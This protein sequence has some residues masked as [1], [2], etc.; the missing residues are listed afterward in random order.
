MSFN[1]SLFEAGSRTPSMGLALGALLRLL[2][3]T[4]TDSICFERHAALHRHA[5]RYHVRHTSV[6]AYELSSLDEI[7]PARICF[8]FFCFGLEFHQNTDLQVMNASP[9]ERPQ[10][11]RILAFLYK[12]LGEDDV[13]SA[14]RRRF[15]VCP[16]T[17]V[18]NTMYQFKNV[19]LVYVLQQT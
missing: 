1:V 2:D 5:K 8:F 19:V 17:Q 3:S 4:T 7:F 12:H 18:R 10:W 15:A 6:G 14:L 9:E 13:C 11:M 16:E